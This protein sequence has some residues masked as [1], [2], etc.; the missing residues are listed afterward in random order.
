MILALETAVGRGSIVVLRSAEVV[1]K[2]D[3]GAAR[4]DELLPAIERI[5][6]DAGASPHDISRVAVST[7]PGSFTGI[8]VGIATALG[9]CRTLKVELIG[10]SALEALGWAAPVNEVTAIIPA[11]RERFAVQKFRKT[12]VYVNSSTSPAS[13]SAN[14]LMHLIRNT[15]ATQYVVA[16]IDDDP[17]GFGTTISPESNVHVV[18]QSLASLIGRYSLIAPAGGLTPIYLNK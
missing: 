7:G 3:H 15:A 17:L 1:A 9:L 8:R 12:G 13:L 16:G 2:T 18:T 14:D 10:I 5:L 6:R 4:A 11:G